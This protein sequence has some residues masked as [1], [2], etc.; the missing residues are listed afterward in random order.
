MPSPAQ[1]I[2]RKLAAIFAADV[3]GYSRLMAQDEVGTLRTLAA[4]REI[5]DRLI[6]EHRGRIANTA[7]DSVLAEFPSVVDAVECA[8]EVQQALAEANEG[9]PEERRMRFRIGVHV[10]DVMVRGADLLG[11]GVNVAA[12]LQTLAAP[13]GV[14][15]SGEAHQY[16][17][18]VLP[19]GYEDLGHQSVRNI[20]EPIRAYKIVRDR[21]P[22]EPTSPA[23][24]PKLSVPDRPSIAV[25][26]F[27]NMSDDRGTEWFAD[28]VVED[29]ITGL[30]R[31]K[32]LVVI[33][34]NSSF[35]YKG[36]A[37]DVKQ[38][39]RELGVRYVL[40]GSVRRAANRVRI[41]TQL[42]ET[43]TGAQVW[44]ERYDALLDDIFAVQD[45]L[46]GNLLSALAP[47][48]EKAEV[49]RAKRKR[50]TNLDAYDLFLH[51]LAIMRTLTREGVDNALRLYSASIASDPDFAA[52]YEWAAMCYSIRKSRNW[53]VDTDQQ[54][55]EATRL[56][57][58]AVYL[59]ADDGVALCYGGHTLSYVG[60]DLQAGARASERAVAL[61]PNLAPALWSSAFANIWDGRPE[62][63]LERLTRAV[64]LSPVDPEIPWFHAAIA[65]AHFHAERYEEAVMWASKSMAAGDIIDGARVLAAALGH[66]GR[67]EEAEAAVTKLR[68]IDPILCVSTLHRVLG[69]YRPEGLERYRVGLRRAGLPE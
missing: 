19:L 53:L 37:V 38:V 54:I 1:P 22:S 39:G 68:Q 15:L 49:A 2:E 27:A 46:S 47:Q 6:G 58:R 7:G 10:G 11:D 30:T 66:L 12:R 56:A 63:A 8:V 41:T 17:R 50:F 67:R 60:G 44:A 52:A 35:T 24:A 40:E 36:R 48:L 28:G 69:P 64:R 65:H 42:V 57:R 21:E 45:Q 31:F 55:S 20:E 18:K 43:R 5:M 26:P 61:N 59:G 34:R 51:A 9:V 4:H 25:L 3:A 33:A 29:L 16:A 32:T 23:V 62:L 14:C 13:G